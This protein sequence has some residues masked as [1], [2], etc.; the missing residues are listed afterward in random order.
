LRRPGLSIYEV[1]A[2]DEEEEE[3]EEEEEYSTHKTL[4]SP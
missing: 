1:V 4:A 2:P 3:E